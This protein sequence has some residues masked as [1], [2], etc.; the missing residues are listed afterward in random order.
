MGAT[1]GGP[2]RGNE[3]FKMPDVNSFEELMES[4]FDIRDDLPES[5][6]ELSDF[7]YLI[8]RELCDR[9]IMLYVTAIT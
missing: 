4:Y 8:M 1:Q 2:P 7:S 6:H 9:V 3:V 5:A